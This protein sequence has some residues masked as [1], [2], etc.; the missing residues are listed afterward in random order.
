MVP[1]I[2][3]ESKVS[4]PTNR[5]GPTYGQEQAGASI[6]A[7]KATFVCFWFSEQAGSRCLQGVSVHNLRAKNRTHGLRMLHFF[8]YQNTSIKIDGILKL[9]DSLRGNL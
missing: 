1:R 7:K 5:T 6:E 4:G 8:I 2:S 3:G 9:S